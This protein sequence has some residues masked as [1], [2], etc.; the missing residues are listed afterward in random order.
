MVELK[1]SRKRDRPHLGQLLVRAG[2]IDPEELEIALELQQT[3][4]VSRALPLGA[5]L[6]ELGLT[7]EK[8]VTQA[9]SRQLH[10]PAVDLDAAQISPDVTRYVDVSLAERFKVFPVGADHE[11]S[12]LR[13]ATADPSNV[14]ALESLTAHSGMMV[15]FFLSDPGT[16]HRAI[17]RYYRPEVVIEARPVT[18]P[19]NPAADA[20]IAEL[21]AAIKEQGA[22]IRTMVE[23][24]DTKGVVRREE[25]LHRL[26]GSPRRPPALPLRRSGRKRVLS[27]L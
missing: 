17:Q 10:V 23:L 18:V 4:V 9:L 27:L 22:A 8:A 13:V 6:V 26:A 21:E 2:C 7:T 24:L 19:A 15:F 14:E 12:L 5:V 25:L 3:G 16:I 1:S 11:R 20:R